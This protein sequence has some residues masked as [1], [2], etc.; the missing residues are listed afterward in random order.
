[1]PKSEIFARGLELETGGHS[2]EFILQA[3]YLVSSPAFLLSAGTE[4]CQGQHIPI[5]G[6]LALAAGE[7][8][9]RLLP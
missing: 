8:G 2:E 7:I 9:C 4:Y 3:D 5:L 1:M 6:E